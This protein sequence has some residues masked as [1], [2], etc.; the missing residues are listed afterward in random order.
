MKDGAER[1][2]E[3]RCRRAC[4]TTRVN[5]RWSG[6]VTRCALVAAIGCSGLV[7]AGTA[8]GPVAAASVLTSSAGTNGCNGRAVAGTTTLT[9]TVDHHRRVV[10]VHVPS[11]YTGTRRVPLVLDLHGSGST[12][13]EQ[14]GFSGMDATADAEGFI[15][16]YPQ[17]AIPAGSGFDWNIPN[18]PLFG[19]QPP[20]ASAAND[21]TFLSDLVGL[22]GRRYCI[23]PSRVYATG[24]SGGARMSSQLACS[25]SGTFAA[26][27]PVS[28]LRLPSPCHATRPVPVIA[29]H[30][31]ADP[32]DPYDGHG[33]PYWT[34]SVPQAAR[35]WARQ[36]GCNG[37][38][39]T[40]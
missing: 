37:V 23:S 15:V 24:F 38:A 32:V 40:S 34:Y 7:V 33:Q 16:A 10:I 30:G 13:A 6:W 2:R 1:W 29:F 27:A 22:L 21:V 25:A 8:T 9:P 14:E 39:A 28:G 11:Q 19:G 26:V 20:P 35:D 4:G 18:V 5:V 12:A 31:T 36:N 17:G 3:R